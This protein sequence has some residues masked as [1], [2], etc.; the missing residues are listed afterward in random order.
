MTDH[1]LIPRATLAQAVEDIDALLSNEEH[2]TSGGMRSYQIGSPTWEL[3][4][5]VKA[6]RDKLHAA[7][8]APCEPVGEVR[9][10]SDAYGGTFVL[11]KQLSVAGMTLY[12]APKEPTT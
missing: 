9:A 12:A 2:A 7:L 4:E 8:D 10:K 5:A 6:Q 11:W 1:V 3:W